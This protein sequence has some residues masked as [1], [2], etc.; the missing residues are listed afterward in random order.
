[1]GD[2]LKWPTMRLETSEPEFG[3]ASFRPSSTFIIKLKDNVRVLARVPG[4]RSEV[5]SGRMGHS[6]SMKDS[7][8]RL[9]NKAAIY[10]FHFGFCFK[11][12][13]AKQKEFLE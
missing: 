6:F 5:F 10:S 11:F 3:Y 12:E 9:N 2:S 8:G 7:N 1:M 4:H 13:Y